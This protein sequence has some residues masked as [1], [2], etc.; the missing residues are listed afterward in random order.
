[1]KLRVETRPLVQSGR[2]T[3]PECAA[4]TGSLPFGNEHRASFAMYDAAQT[5]L[6]QMC[7]FRDMRFAANRQLE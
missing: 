3:A 5:R 1:M 4:S 2:E 6:Q 7:T